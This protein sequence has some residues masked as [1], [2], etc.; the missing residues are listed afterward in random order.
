MIPCPCCGPKWY[1]L[2][3]IWLYRHVWHQPV[4]PELRGWEDAGTR[5]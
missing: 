3:H 1:A 2:L 4:P 5:D